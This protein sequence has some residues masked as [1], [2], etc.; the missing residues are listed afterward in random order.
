VRRAE[1]AESEGCLRLSEILASN[2]RALGLETPRLFATPLGAEPKS[3]SHRTIVGRKPL[4]AL[5]GPQ[6]ALFAPVG[7]GAI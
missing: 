4:V 5:R 6:A 7:N 3:I 1:N 2:S